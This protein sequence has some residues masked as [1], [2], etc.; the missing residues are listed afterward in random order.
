MWH[1]L[2]VLQLLLF[3]LDGL[4]EVVVL[5]HNRKH[6]LRSVYDPSCQLIGITV[7]FIQCYMLYCRRISTKGQ[8]S[9]KVDVQELAN[10]GYR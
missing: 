4:L 6:P 9:D 1:M 2:M 8:A 7:L 5:E 10:L 3:L